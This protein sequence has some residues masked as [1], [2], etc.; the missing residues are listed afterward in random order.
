MRAAWHLGPVSGGY[1]WW[2]LVSLPEILVF[3]FFMITD[4]GRSP[5][6]RWHALPT[7]SA[8]A[9]SRRS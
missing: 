5:A 3:M 2:V 7:A 1:L 9:C 4:P 6:G 8:W